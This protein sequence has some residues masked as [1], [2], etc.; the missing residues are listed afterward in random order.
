MPFKGAYPEAIF[1]AIKNEP[2]PPLRAPGREI[3]ETLETIVMR[4][5][6]KDPEKRYQTAREFARDL[7]LL[8]GRTVPLDLLTGP[9]PPLPPVTSPKPP[10]R[11]QRMRAA[12]TPTRAIVTAIVAIAAIAAGYRWF[13]QPVVRIP[14]GDCPGCKLHGRA[15]PG[16]ISPCPYRIIARGARGFTQHP[17]RALSTPGG[18][19]AAVHRFGRC[20][21]PRSHP[22]GSHSQ[23]RPLCRHTSSW[24][25]EAE[26][27]S[28]GPRFAM[29]SREPSRR[30]SNPKVS[31]PRCP[32]TRCFG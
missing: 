28:R 13:T 24:L 19:R 17:C 9:L 15:D 6:E 30:R 1:Y 18:N 5:L 22:G 11:W 26:P 20:V 27:G 12:V 7:R 32:R 10:S 3:P 29:S 2:V 31:L 23:R 21:E 8:L 14:V 4:A 25:S 16:R